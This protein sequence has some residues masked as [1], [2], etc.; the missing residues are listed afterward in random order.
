[1]LCGVVPVDNTVATDSSPVSLA[2]RP[3]KNGDRLIAEDQEPLA[4]VMS[5]DILFASNGKPESSATLQPILRPSRI[6]IFRVVALTRFTNT[7]ILVAPPLL[8]DNGFAISRS[9]DALY[10]GWV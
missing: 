9:S 7:V 2:S 1:M 5:P 6:S 3:I 10:A 8:R 4:G